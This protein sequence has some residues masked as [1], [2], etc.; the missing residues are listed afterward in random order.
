MSLTLR[1]VSLPLEEFSLELDLEIPAQVTAIFGPSGA[2]KTSLFDLIAGLRRPASAHSPGWLQRWRRYRLH[3]WI[4]R[5]AR[6]PVETRSPD[7]A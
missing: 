2:G 4:P 1:N 5:R 6:Q 7:L 3:D